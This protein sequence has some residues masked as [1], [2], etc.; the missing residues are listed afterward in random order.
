MDNLKIVSIAIIAICMIVI[1]MK[2]VAERKFY[3]Y[4]FKLYEHRSIVNSENEEQCKISGGEW[5]KKDNARACKAQC[6]EQ[7][8]SE[9]SIS[10]AEDVEECIDRECYKCQPVK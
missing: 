4:Q 1:A 2:S 3:K 9:D 5:Y 7:Y 10:S 6:Q 8:G